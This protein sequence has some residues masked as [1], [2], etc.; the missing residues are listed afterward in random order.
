MEIK[1]VFLA[2]ILTAVLCF[3]GNLLA[4]S[5]GTGI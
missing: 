1:G 4:Y 2:A 5:G 3:S